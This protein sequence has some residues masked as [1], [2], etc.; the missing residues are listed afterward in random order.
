AAYGTLAGY[1]ASVGRKFVSAIHNGSKGIDY[2]RKVIKL[3]PEYAD[4]YLSIGLY[5]Y[6][7]GSL[8]LPFKLMAAMGGVHGS[9]KRGIDELQIAVTK[10]KFASDDARTMLVALYERDGQYDKAL[11][12]LNDLSGRYSQNYLY[13]LER[14]VALGRCGKRD[15]SYA[16]FDEVLKN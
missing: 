16:A 9:R 1:E 13:S 2:H 3:D 10:G 4:A 14:A 7:V 8:P 15:E 5:D 11:G 6:I 12:L